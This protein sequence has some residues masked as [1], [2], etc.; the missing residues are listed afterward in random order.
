M[1]NQKV[2]DRLPIELGVRALDE[3]YGNP[4]RGVGVP[5]GDIG[6]VI[7]DTYGSPRFEDVVTSW[8]NYVNDTYG[9]ASRRIPGEAVRFLPE[10]ERTDEDTKDI[11][12]H[13][14][15]LGR[16][17]ADLKR[18]KVE[19]LDLDKLNTHNHRLLVAAKLEAVVQGSYRELLPPPKTQALPRLPFPET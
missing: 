1:T 19:Y 4:G 8:R 17:V 7:G 2:V 18:V 15:R 3:K 6:A 11:R 16:S 13:S 12:S 10:D 5:Y 9:I 14:R